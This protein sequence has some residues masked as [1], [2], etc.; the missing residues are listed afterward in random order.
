MTIKQEG[1][2]D[3]G[4]WA[5]HSG[6][7]RIFYIITFPEALKS[8]IHVVLNFHQLLRTW[9]LLDLSYSNR[10]PDGANERHIQG[11]RCFSNP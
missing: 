5:E 7:V 10:E 1:E 9:K 8:F 6:C 4:N 2:D 3:F 11:L